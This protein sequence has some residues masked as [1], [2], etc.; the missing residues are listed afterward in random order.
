[1]VNYKRIIF[2]SLFITILIFLAGLLLGL[3]LDDTRV[4]DIITNLNQNE[5]NRE[6]YLVEQDFIKNL[7]GGTCYLS[8]Q[9]IN[10]L[11]GE[12]TKLGQ[13]ITRYEPKGI[14]REDEYEYL[15]RKYFLLEIKTYTF[16]TTLRKECDYNFNTVLFFY[17]INHQESLNQGYILDSLV[18]SK[19]DVHVFSLDRNFEESSLETVKFHYNI[20]YSPSLI[21][22]DKIRKEGLAS[23]EELKEILK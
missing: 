14:L 22:N 13:L 12:L 9:R 10:T 15:K 6:S 16:F 7:G 3:S 21:I 5:L 20:S 4:N 1:M 11:S 19:K 2:V 17:D 23:L 18:E 8:D